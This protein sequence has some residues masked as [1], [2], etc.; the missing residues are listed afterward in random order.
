MFRKT[1]YVFGVGVFL[2]LF[3]GC[4]TMGKKSDLTIQGLKNQISVLEAQLQKKN[5]EIINLKEALSSKSETEERAVAKPL[6]KKRVI[7]EIKARPNVRQIQIALKNAGYNPGALD[8]KMG[9]ETRD[10]IR[11]FQRANNLGVDGKIGKETWGLLRDYLYDK[12]K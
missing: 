12:R 11:A 5:R 8:G 3:S 1:A 10:A 9:K 6:V 7:G 4:A 2:F